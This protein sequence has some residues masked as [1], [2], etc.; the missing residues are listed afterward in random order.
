MDDT[1]Q[2]DSDRRP[3]NSKHCVSS[4]HAFST[5]ALVEL[6]YECLRSSI[7][8]EYPSAVNN[9]GVCFESS[10]SSRSTTVVLK[11]RSSM[12]L[13]RTVSS[14]RM[15][16]SRQYH[17]CSKKDGAKMAYGKNTQNQGQRLT[18]TIPYTIRPNQRTTVRN[19]RNEGRR[20]G[21]WTPSCPP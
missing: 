20:K 8:R 2:A 19:D 7:E 13:N 6:A 9:V 17:L 18:N 15:H 14:Y 5:H 16:C 1:D 4:T 11:E 21:G 3:L 12:D 10:I